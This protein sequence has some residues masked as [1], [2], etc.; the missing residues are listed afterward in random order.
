[1]V[2]CDTLPAEALVQV[3]TA[4][5]FV[6]REDVCIATIGFDADDNAVVI[7]SATDETHVACASKRAVAAAVLDRVEEFAR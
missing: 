5:D 4:P 2:G 1:M 3:D 7:V 6:A